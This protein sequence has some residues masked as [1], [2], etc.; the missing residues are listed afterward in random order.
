MKEV[1]LALSNILLTFSILFVLYLTMIPHG[2][3]RTG[4]DS[5]SAHYFNYN[6]NPIHLFED[7]QHAS[8]FYL[9]VDI[10]GNIILFVPFGI[11][12]TMRFPELKVAHVGFVGAFFSSTIECIQLFLPNRMTD[13]DDVILNT[14][15]AIVGYL[16]F[17]FVESAR[18]ENL[19]MTR[20]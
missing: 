13:I 1:K 6:L 5:G 7:L 12:L 8:L 19:E 20:R 3:I 18:E 2:R 10:I 9:I 15:G 14:T 11:F 17:R 4:M 16:L